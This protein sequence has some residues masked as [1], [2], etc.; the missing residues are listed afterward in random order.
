MVCN[1]K[2]RSIERVLLSLLTLSTLKDSAILLKGSGMRTARIRWSRLHIWRLQI[3][4]SSICAQIQHMSTLQD[5]SITTRM[6][7]WLTINDTYW[8]LSFHFYS[9]VYTCFRLH[10]FITVNKSSVG[11]Q[12]L[13]KPKQNPRRIKHYNS[14]FECEDWTHRF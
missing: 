14:W 4:F 2:C 7:L 13:E 1:A 10:F 12:T 5:L 3:I 6:V 8:A 9:F 11:G